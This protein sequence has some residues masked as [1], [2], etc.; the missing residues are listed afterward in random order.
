LI[1][2]SLNLSIGD[3]TAK[4]AVNTSAFLQQSIADVPADQKFYHQYFQQKEDFDSKDPRKTKKKA[5]KDEKKGPR[6]EEQEEA[7]IDEFTQELFQ[8]EMASSFPGGDPDADIDG[9]DD[10]DLQDA[11]GEHWQ[12]PDDDDELIDDGADQENKFAAMDGDLEGLDDEVELASNVDE[13][14]EDIPSFGDD[15]DGDEDDSKSKTKKG[16]SGAV[17]KGPSFADVPDEIDVDDDE[18]MERLYGG[19]AKQAAA[20]SKSG[21][22]GMKAAIA[23]ARAAATT[24][25]VL[26]DDDD[27][28]FSGDDGLFGDGASD[29]DDDEDDAKAN[30]KKTKDRGLGVV[31]GI[32]NTDG[33]A[34]SSAD[35]FASILE[36]SGSDAAHPKFVS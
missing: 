24:P 22:K 6:D 26:P 21:K 25:V 16:S 10:D 34:F 5:G 14:D 29:S 23:T 32:G 33:D 13:D 8:K 18:A 2:C 4:V 9:L 1:P 35:D 12:E 17:S 7:E 31:G 20:T 30:K 19:I 15:D 36:T 3:A 27:E 28:E 11:F